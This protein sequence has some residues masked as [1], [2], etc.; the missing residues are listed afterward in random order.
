M[1]QLINF[2]WTILGFAAVVAYWVSAG[3]SALFYLF[4]IASIIPAILPQKVADHLQLSSNTKFY[5]RFGI[6]FIRKFVQHGDFANRLERRNDPQYR[7]MRQSAIPAS[8]LKT[9]MMYERYHL[10]CFIFFLL[11]SVI[12]VIKG[13]Y[14]QFLLITISNIFYNFYPMLLQQYNRVRILKINRVK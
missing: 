8:Y 14:L 1:N 2:F 5:E 6:R 4:L 12:A 13:Y 11:T 9:V 10:M 7:V 3:L